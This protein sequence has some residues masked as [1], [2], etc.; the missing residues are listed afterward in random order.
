MSMLH[1]ILLIS[2]PF[3]YFYIVTRGGQRAKR[4]RRTFEQDG[5]VFYNGGKQAI[6]HNRRQNNDC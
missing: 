3:I 1:N 6:K 5:A 4:S 2:A